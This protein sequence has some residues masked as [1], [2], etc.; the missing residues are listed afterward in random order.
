ML[1]GV[2]P[3]S[4]SI[5][6]LLVEYDK[7]SKW[8]FLYILRSVERNSAFPVAFVSSLLPFMQRRKINL[9]FD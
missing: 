5:C 3:N 6:A 1:F 2:Q 8:R 4:I 9:F 7:E